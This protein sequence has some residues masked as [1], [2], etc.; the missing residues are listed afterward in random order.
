MTERQ[1]APEE[2]KRNMKR[3]EILLL[4]PGRDASPTQGYPHRFV[5]PVSDQSAMITDLNTLAEK[6]NVRVNCF[7]Q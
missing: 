7:A 1:N 2:F 5:S 6:G 4:L 3:L